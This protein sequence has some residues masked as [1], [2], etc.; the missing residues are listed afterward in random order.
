MAQGV[1]GNCGRE[2][3]GEGVRFCPNCGARIG[4]NVAAAGGAD[5]PPVLGREPSPE[6]PET[7][8]PWHAAPPV[9]RLTDEGGTGNDGER[10]RLITG[11]AG[12]DTALGFVAVLAVNLATPAG[13]RQFAEEALPIAGGGGVVYLASIA[14]YLLIRR[15]APQFGKG[16]RLG[17]LVLLGIG[18]VLLLLAILLILGVLAICGQMFN[19]P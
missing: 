14:V 3:E 5:R 7:A 11:N 8:N 2:A 1:C 4:A 16:W 9:P 19:R 6:S 10:G 15:R 13:V 12:G 17:L 18:A